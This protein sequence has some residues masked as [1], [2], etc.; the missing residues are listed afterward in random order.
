MKCKLHFC[1]QANAITRY[2]VTAISISI[3]FSSEIFESVDP[4]LGSG[5]STSRSLVVIFSSEQLDGEYFA[6]K[7]ARKSNFSSIMLTMEIYQH[8]M[9]PV[10][11]R[12]EQ[13]FHTSVWRDIFRKEFLISQRKE[14]PPAEMR[15]HLGSGF[16]ANMWPSLYQN[17][18]YA[19]N[20]IALRPQGIQIGF[21]SMHHALGT[22]EISS[23]CTN[24][25]KYLTKITPACLTCLNV[26]HCAF[27]L[28]NMAYKVQAM[29][30]CE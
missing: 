22:L 5:H 24:H 21:V 14:K 30:C 12:D 3:N 29:H 2:K 26:A 25:K 7:F 1:P 20:R 15:H 27:Y 13:V 6:D 4:H 17:R 16:M 28:R 23:S 8:D 18:I 9:G 11:W 19:K 10:K